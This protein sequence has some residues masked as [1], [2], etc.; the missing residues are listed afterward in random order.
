M[1]QIAAQHSQ[2]QSKFKKVYEF[3][4]RTLY[5]AQLIPNEL[6][7]CNGATHRRT[8]KNEKL[9]NKTLAL[10]HSHKMDFLKNQ[11][12]KLQIDYLK[13]TKFNF[14]G[15]MIEKCVKLFR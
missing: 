4:L 14:E 7:V 5:L 10:S 6:F 15:I 8:V 11:N 12:P 9:K 2:L 3:R 1:C 13:T